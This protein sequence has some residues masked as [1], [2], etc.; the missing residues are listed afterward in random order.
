MDIFLHSWKTDCAS[1]SAYSDIAG[2]QL[3]QYESG[4][5]WEA[6]PETGSFGNFPEERSLAMLRTGAVM[7]GLRKEKTMIASEKDILNL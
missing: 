1:C 6:L 2:L 4:C 5:S 7:N 3:G